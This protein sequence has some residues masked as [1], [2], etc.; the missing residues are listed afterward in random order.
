M[1]ILSRLSEKILNPKLLTYFMSDI[2][3]NK[4]YFIGDVMRALKTDFS[5]I[6][7]LIYPQVFKLF[8]SSWLSQAA[9]NKLAKIPIFYHLKGMSNNRHFS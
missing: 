1:E 8:T 3:L 2:A 6:N 9:P 7:Q 4:L 5:F